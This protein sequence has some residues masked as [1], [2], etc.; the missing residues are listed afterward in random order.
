MF[1]HC[2]ALAAV[3][4]L[5][6]STQAQTLIG[7]WKTVDDETKEAK[8]YV[9]L[10]EQNGKVYGKVTKLLKS[11]PDRKC[12]QCP[13][14]RKNQPILGMVILENLTLKDGF[15]QD[16]K[17]LDPEKGKWYTCKVWLKDGDP[18]VL[19]VRGYIG[20]FYRTQYWYRVE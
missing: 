4:L 17:I 3:L 5:S 9:Q 15:Y 7:T 2:S 10:Y 14:E 16:G 18:N 11:S 20:F 19:T 1:K 12:D 8:S 6:L 13:G